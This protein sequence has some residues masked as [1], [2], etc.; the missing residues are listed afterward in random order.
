MGEGFPVGKHGV[1]GS[2]GNEFTVQH[3]GGEDRL[4]GPGGRGAVL[5]GNES[6]SNEVGVG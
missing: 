3:L 4:R 1:G 2:L 6:L 5:L